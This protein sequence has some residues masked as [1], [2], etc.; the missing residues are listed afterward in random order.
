MAIC[1]PVPLGCLKADL[2]G[3]HHDPRRDLRDA[4][5]QQRRGAPLVDAH[6]RRHVRA[7]QRPRKPVVRNVVEHV[8]AKHT[9]TCWLRGELE[10]RTPEACVCVACLGTSATWQT[11]HF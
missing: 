4:V 7:L 2:Q 9:M 1:H 10:V 3:G 5:D 8:L 11:Q 6:Q